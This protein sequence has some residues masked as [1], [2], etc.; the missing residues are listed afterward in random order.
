M[1]Q[2]TLPLRSALLAAATLASCS[3][4]SARMS[5]TIVATADDPAELRLELPGAADATV[6]L[7]NEGPGDARFV[8][9]QPDT[10]EMAKGMLPA[11]GRPFRWRAAAPLVEVTFTVTDRAV[12]GYRMEA[13]QNNE[14]D[15]RIAP[16]A[17][18]TR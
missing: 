9:V 1:T 16:A 18:A 3:S 14:A 10:D 4:F 15:A 5:G 11:G 8:L 17:P 7:W 12:I 13:D 6:E 2:R